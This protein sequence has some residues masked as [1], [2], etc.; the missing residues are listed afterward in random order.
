MAVGIGGKDFAD[1][2]EAATVFGADA[3]SKE[4]L[5]MKS[6]T[7]ADMLFE[8]V[9]GVFR[10]EVDHVAIASNFSDDG[11]GGNFGDKKVGFLENG[12]AVFERGIAE[13]IY[14]AVDDDF[15]KRL[16]RFQDLFNGAMAGKLETI[17]K[18]ILVKFGSGDPAKTGCSGMFKED[19]V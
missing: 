18:P 2:T 7:V 19:G 11:S 15:V 13:E 9:F 4:G 6:G 1:R 17:T 5:F 3:V 8:A 16:F 12:D 14:S 10:G